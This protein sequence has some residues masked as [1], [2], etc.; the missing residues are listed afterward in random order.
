MPGDNLPNLPRTHYRSSEG[1]HSQQPT[2]PYH[3][4][5]MS[6]SIQHSSQ[7]SSQAEY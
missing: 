5:F 1:K 4:T 2:M 3:P 6:S 7:Q